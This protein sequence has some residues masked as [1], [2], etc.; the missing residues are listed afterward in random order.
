MTQD[1]SDFSLEQEKQ[2]LTRLQRLADGIFMLAM[3]LMVLQFDLPNLDQSLSSEQITQ[4]LLAQLPA[5]Y[6]YLGTFILIVFY[7]LSHLEQFKYYRKTDTIH[8]WLN[9]LSLMFVV[10]IP[11]ANDLS[12]LEGL[13]VPIQIFYSLDL[14]LVGLFSCLSWWYASSNYRLIDDTLAQESITYITLESSIE[15]IICLVS[16]LVSLLNPMYW[17]ASF[18]LIIPIY[19]LLNWWSKKK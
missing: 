1:K 15:P 7:W 2:L 4:F 14:F 13:N 9:L 5:L 19:L 10:L 3:T 11:Y 18:F 6:I 17:D 16:I 8:L 12:N